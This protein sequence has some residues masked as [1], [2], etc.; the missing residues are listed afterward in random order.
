MGLERTYTNNKV[1]T[2]FKYG[3]DEFCTNNHLNVGNTC[4]F[5]VI[6]EA[7]CSYDEDKEWEEQVYDEAKLKV[8]VRNTN[9]GCLQ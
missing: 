5:S 4:F 9:D 1:C 7:T 3:W 2:S 8:E 6:H